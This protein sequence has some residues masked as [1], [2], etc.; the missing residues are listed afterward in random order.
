MRH[1]GLMNRDPVRLKIRERTCTIEVREDVDQ[2]LPTLGH[3]ILTHLDLVLD[4]PNR[5]L[6]GNPAHG[7]EQMLELYYHWSEIASLKA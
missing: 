5:R 2:H 3:T 7:G 4:A 6:I 1:L